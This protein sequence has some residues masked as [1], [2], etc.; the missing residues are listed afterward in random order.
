MKSSLEQAEPPAPGSPQTV[1]D[2]LT[3]SERRMASFSLILAVVQFVLVDVYFRIQELPA[4]NAYLS[5]GA[6]V[7]VPSD[8]IGYFPLVASML[9]LAA[10][11][12]WPVILANQKSG[13]MA[14]AGLFLGSAWI[15][16]SVPLTFDFLIDSFEP[17]LAIVAL[18]V[19]AGTRYWK[20][21]TDNSVAFI[22][23]PLVT[24]I[25]AGDGFGHLSGLFCSSTGL[26]SCA[27]K[28][29]SDAYLVV[30]LL[31]L[32]YFTVAYRD[33]RPTLF[34]VLATILTPVLI[35]LGLSL[36]P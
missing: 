16:A 9:L 23:A 7:E 12:A 27:A 24:V 35:F 33:H 26:S 2:R 31:P 8:G 36:F 11:V 21:S 20:G 29:V 32:A 14:K 1:W 15:L 30:M 6:P 28:A 18:F 19:F 4:I 34:L 13:Q 25:A 22:L 10:L 3:V 17:K 5:G